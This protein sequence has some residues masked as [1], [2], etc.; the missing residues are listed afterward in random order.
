[1]V[2]GM[3]SKLIC[4][5]TSKATL[6]LCDSGMG[7]KLFALIP[8]DVPEDNSAPK[9]LLIRELIEAIAPNSFRLQVMAGSFIA[10]GRGD[11]L[12]PIF[13]RGLSTNLH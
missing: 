1:M 2:N 5:N 4:R 11:P 9:V 8:G 6:D 13:I 12:L 7:E 3:T 10:N